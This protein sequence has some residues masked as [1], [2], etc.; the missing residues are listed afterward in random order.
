MTALEYK[1]FGKLKLTK[2]DIFKMFVIFPNFFQKLPFLT[3]F[4]LLLL[5]FFIFPDFS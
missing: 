1:E 3:D 4:Y 5:F 2:F